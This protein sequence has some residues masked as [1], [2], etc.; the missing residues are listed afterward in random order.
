MSIAIIAKTAVFQV[1]NGSKNWGIIIIMYFC[2]QTR[3]P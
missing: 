3:S 1:G 2:P